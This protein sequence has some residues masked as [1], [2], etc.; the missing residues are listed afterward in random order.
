MPARRRQRYTTARATAAISKLG[1][2]DLILSGQAADW[3]AGVVGCGIAGMLELPAITFARSISEDGSTVE[4][5]VEN[6]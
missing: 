1:K 6:G 2:P 4:R 5:V 3:D